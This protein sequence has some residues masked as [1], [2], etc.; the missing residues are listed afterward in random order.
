MNCEMNTWYFYLTQQSRMYYKLSSPNA[1]FIA[2]S[3]KNW[4]EPFK[5]CSFASGMMLESIVSRGTLKKIDFF[6]FLSFL[7][8]V[9]YSSQTPTYL[10]LQ[11]SATAGRFSSTQ[12]LTPALC[13]TAVVPP[14][15]QLSQSTFLMSLQWTPKCSIC[16][17]L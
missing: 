8:P 9:H 2:Y 14:Y 11:Y 5:Y 3:P 10:F 4:D 15:H 12:Q 16:Q 7:D 13:W 6:F 1:L 17:R